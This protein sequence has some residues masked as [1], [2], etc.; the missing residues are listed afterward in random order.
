VKRYTVP[1]II[2]ARD[3]GQS[4]EDVVDILIENGFRFQDAGWWVD[5]EIR[6]EDVPDED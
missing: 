3:T 6:V 2:D 4:P 5:G 1:L